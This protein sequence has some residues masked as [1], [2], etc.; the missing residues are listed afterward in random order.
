[1]LLSQLKRK[2]RIESEEFQLALQSIIRA[3]CDNILTTNLFLSYETPFHEVLAML[4]EETILSLKPTPTGDEVLGWTLDDGPWMYKLVPPLETPGE[5]QR[6][7]Q[8]LR[9]GGG[10]LV[11]MHVSLHKL[12]Q[13]Q[14]DY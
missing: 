3:N 13:S 9:Q 1:M 7:L 11:L 8:G 10:D 12:S 5:Y 4:R 6:V 2:T 14:G